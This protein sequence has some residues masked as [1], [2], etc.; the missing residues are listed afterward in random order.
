MVRAKNAKLVS[1]LQNVLL[2]LLCIVTLFPFAVMLSTA[3]KDMKEIRSASMTLLPKE[4]TLVP[5]QTILSDSS[6][7]RYFYN[8]FK[9]TLWSI[10]GALL[11]NSLAGFAFARLQFRGRKWLF[12]L[13]LLGMMVPAQVTMLPAYVIMRYI[14]FAGG[15]DILGRGGMGLLNSNA[16]LIIAY[17]CGS[18]GVFLY[19]QFL[20]NFPASLD[21]AARVDG[22]SYFGMYLRIYLPLSK[23][24][25]ATMVVIRATATWN[26]YIWPLL[27]TQKEKMYTVQLALSQFRSDSGD[28]WNLIMAATT[29]IMLPVI[30]LFLFLQRYF[31]AG[32]VTTGIKG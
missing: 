23:P 30:L 11:I 15:N 16:G 6:W 25:L 13:L 10:L 3:F 24:V 28:I 19:R 18:Y 1:I 8:S 7:I 12:V 20:V 32:I 5:F 29:L 2:F 27:I 26:D 31:V 22:L 4:P 9:L 17:L 14:P 21:D